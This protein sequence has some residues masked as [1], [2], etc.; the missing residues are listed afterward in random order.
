MECQLL[1]VLAAAIATTIV[2]GF[3]L[4][5]VQFVTH[6]PT[7]QHPHQQPVTETSLDKGKLVTGSKDYEAN[8]VTT[9]AVQET[10]RK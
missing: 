7:K 8:Q 3:A 2:L 9:I 10:V 5:M 6:Y 4:M 1:T